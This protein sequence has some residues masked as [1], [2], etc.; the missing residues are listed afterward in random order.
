MH[1]DELF[2]TATNPCIGHLLHGEKS[3]AAGIVHQID[4]AMVP[5]GI[6]QFPDEFVPALFPLHDLARM[7]G[8]MQRQRSSNPLNW[9]RS[10]RQL[11]TVM[12]NI[13]NLLISSS[14]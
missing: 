14:P 3:I 13:C 6:L 5:C 12:V 8:R 1:T 2:V 9:N 10:T 7:E 11:F 4:L